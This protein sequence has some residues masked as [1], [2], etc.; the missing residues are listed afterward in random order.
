M[1]AAYTLS[2]CSVALRALAQT[3]FNGFC[4]RFDPLSS[5]SCGR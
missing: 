2:S 5:G 1:Q 4:A 3:F